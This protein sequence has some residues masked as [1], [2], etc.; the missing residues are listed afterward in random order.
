[1]RPAKEFLFSSLLSFL[2]SLSFRSFIFPPFKKE[3]NKR[4]ERKREGRE[5]ILREEKI[6]R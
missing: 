4:L 5:R 6:L 2:F 3:E 1:V